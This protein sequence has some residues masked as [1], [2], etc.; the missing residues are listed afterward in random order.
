MKLLNYQEVHKVKSAKKNSTDLQNKGFCTSQNMYYYG[1]KIHT[2]C[3]IQG[4]IKRFDISKASV[5][6]IHYLKEIKNEFSNCVVLGDKDY[7]SA[8]YQLYLF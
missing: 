4:V 2:I 1:Y 6:N 5:H 7:L 8:D 3:S